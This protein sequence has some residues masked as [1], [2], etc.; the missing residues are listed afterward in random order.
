ML[1][2]SLNTHLLKQEKKYWIEKYWHSWLVYW[3]GFQCLNNE[4]IPKIHLDFLFFQQRIWHETHYSIR[5]MIDDRTMQDE[6]LTFVYYSVDRK[7]IIE[8]E[9]NSNIQ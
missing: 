3:K 2:V 5:Q 1:P 4:N 7:R 8:K 9:W 6:A